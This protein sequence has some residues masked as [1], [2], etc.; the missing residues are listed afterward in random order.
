MKT[1]A[2]VPVKRFDQGKSRLGAVLDESARAALSR[3]MFDRVVGEVLGGMVA[4]GE[5]EG[6]L[7]VT[8]GDDVA[9]RAQAAGAEVR[10]A[11]GV[12]P[13][14]KL[15]V[16][17]DE[18]LAALAARGAEAALVIMGDLPALEAD[19]V[20]A[21]AALLAGHDVVLAPDAEGAGTNALAMRLPAPMA[22]RFCGGASLGD[23]EEGAR[24]QGLS[25]ARCE[26]AGFRFDV[27]RPED[28]VRVRAA[29]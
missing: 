28:Y 10:L 25:V 14:R 21:L 23:H 1:W 16:V 29:S 2:L 20:R 8:D 12:G 27:D 4:R 15:G 3:V 17:V 18:G 22:T 26:R 7:V 13:G 5:L 19:D 6:A 11:P 24:A 9:A